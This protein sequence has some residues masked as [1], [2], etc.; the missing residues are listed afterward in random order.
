MLLSSRSLL[1]PSSLLYRCDNRGLNRRRFWTT[2]MMMMMTRFTTTTLETVLPHHVLRRPLLEH[3]LQHTPLCDR[4]KIEQN[5]YD[6]KI[7]EAKGSSFS[8]K[9]FHVASSIRPS[10]RRER[11]G[12]RSERLSK[13]DQ[14]TKDIVFFSA[15][16]FQSTRTRT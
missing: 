15:R 4:E 7:Q 6:L 13:D 12:G 3:L 5:L 8:P 16:R 11:V 1:H 2:T 14:M 10:R 9:F